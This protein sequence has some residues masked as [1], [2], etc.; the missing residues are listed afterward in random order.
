MLQPQ[1]KTLWYLYFGHGPV[2]ATSAEAKTMSDSGFSASDGVLNEYFLHERRAWACPRDKVEPSQMGRCLWGGVLAFT[3]ALAPARAL[4]RY[5]QG[6][7]LQQPR[8]TTVPFAWIEER[9]TLLIEV[10]MSNAS[11]E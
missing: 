1:A 11:Q 10:V 5:L 9:K 3:L 6:T 8:L 2:T 7:S 4:C